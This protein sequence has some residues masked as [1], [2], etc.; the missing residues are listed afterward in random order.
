MRKFVII[1]FTPFLSLAAHASEVQYNL[2]IDGITCQSCINRSEAA[3]K[4]IDGV[5]SVKGDVE[6][7]TVTVCADEKVSLTD[8]QLTALFSDKGF[9][10][11]GMKKQEQC[12][13]A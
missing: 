2:K 10:Y 13:P 9:N 4:E 11:R 3:L 8:K 5:K 1:L 7:G 6:E 12:D